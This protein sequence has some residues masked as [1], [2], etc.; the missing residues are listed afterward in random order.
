MGD[1]K[2]LLKSIFSW[3]LRAFSFWFIPTINNKV[4]VA[5]EDAKQSVEIYFWDAEKVKPNQEK[6]SA[7]VEKV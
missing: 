2:N 6:K 5:D 3:A 4:L 1:E 7:V